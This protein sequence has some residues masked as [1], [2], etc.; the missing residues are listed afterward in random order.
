MYSEEKKCDSRNFEKKKNKS[1]IYNKC[2]FLYSFTKSRIIN[3][4]IDVCLMLET[5]LEILYYCKSEKNVCTSKAGAHAKKKNPKPRA[6][7]DIPE[8]G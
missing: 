2:Y 6:L 5:Y 8:L 4:E 3:W 7:S 1:K